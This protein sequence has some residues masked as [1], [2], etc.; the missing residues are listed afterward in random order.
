MAV[1][2][3]GNIYVLDMTPGVVQVFT[4][5]G[6]V[7][8]RWLIRVRKTHFL[9]TICASPD[10]EVF[11]AGGIGAVLKGG[12]SVVIYKFS[13]QGDL[14]KTWGR[15]NDGD[16]ESDDGEFLGGTSGL[17]CGPDGRIYVG[18]EGADRIQVFS[19]DGD[20]LSSVTGPPGA[21][22]NGAIALVSD[23]LVATDTTSGSVSRFRLAP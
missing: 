23:G 19:S 4:P 17:A 20:Y 14:V 22:P 10:G 13:P 12:R 3:D 5:E 6:K 7:V 21:A 8:A 16:D 18:D 1:G 2:Y 11:V 9:T 15:P